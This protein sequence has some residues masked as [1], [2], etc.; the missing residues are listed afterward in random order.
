LLLLGL[1]VVILCVVMAALG[2]GRLG[3]MLQQVPLNIVVQMIGSSAAHM[4][5]LALGVGFASILQFLLLLAASDLL[6]V[7]IDIEEN[8]RS[9]AYYIGPKL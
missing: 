6:R 5:L 1:I 3:S 9:T 8:T 2:A 4:L 7:L